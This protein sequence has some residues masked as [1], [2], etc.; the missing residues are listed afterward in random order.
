[1]EFA[2]CDSRWKLRVGIEEGVI[3]AGVVGWNS[4]VEKQAGL[5]G[6]NSGLE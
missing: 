3:W 4:G 1:M 6:W 2:D 5:A